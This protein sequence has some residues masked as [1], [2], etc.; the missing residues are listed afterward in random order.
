[1][2]RLLLIIKSM[3]VRQW[4]KNIFVLMPLIFSGKLFDMPLFF[5]VLEAFF[6]FCLAASGV[7]IINDIRDSKKDAFHPLKK[8]R[9][10]ASG[11]LSASSALSASFVLITAS[12]AW[13]HHLSAALV[14]LIL[15]YVGIHILYTFRFKREVILDVIII[16]LGFELRVWAGGVVSASRPSI[17]LELC[18]FLLAVFLALIKRRQEKLSLYTDAAKHRDVLSHYKIYFLDQIITIS[19][20]LA[21]VF[22]GL[23]TVWPDV[24]LRIGSTNMAYTI[25][26]VIYGIFRYLYVVH[27]KK[28]TGDPTEIVL[29]DLPLI[30]DLALWL[31]VSGC[32]IYLR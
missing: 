32:L 27:A 6:I 19:A 22:Y 15:F 2:K 20:A 21:I 30:I 29:S 18:V 24:A 9:P 7:Y 13:A 31:I 8:S 3:R 28:T 5:N 12:L 10:I 16:A 14:L 1:M 4:I 11:A 25:P 26:F 23:Y 17:W